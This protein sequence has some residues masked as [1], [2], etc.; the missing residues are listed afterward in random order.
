[1]SDT[2]CLICMDTAVNP[3]TVQCGSDVPH[4]VCSN[5]EVQW[6]LKSKPTQE[7]RII[8]CPACRGIEA[9][10]SHRS[11]ASLQ[12]E[13]THVYAELA[14]KKDKTSGSP[15]TQRIC[16]YIRILENIASIPH[17]QLDGLMPE[18]TTFVQVPPVSVSRRDRRQIEVESR[19]LRTIASRERE[20]QQRHERLEIQHQANI[21]ARRAREERETAARRARAEQA[22]PHSTSVW[23]ESGNIL[24]GTCTTQRRT[25]RPCSYA[26]CVKRVCFRCDKCISH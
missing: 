20:R 5:C 8:T 13:L 11:A 24:N 2:E 26:D 22:A 6:R 23:C 1:M 14:L 21:R 7:G 19:T 10:T 12:V 18:T 9:D 3:Y 25:S 17:I 4:I 16:E 15:L